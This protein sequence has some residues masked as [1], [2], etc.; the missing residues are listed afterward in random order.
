MADKEIIRP[1][2]QIDFLPEVRQAG[3]RFLQ[4]IAQ[5]VNA[6]VARLVVLEAVAVT[7]GNSHDHS[8]GD[9]AQIAYSGLSG[10]PTYVNYVDRGDPSAVDFATAAFTCDNTWRDLD[11]SSVVP[12]GAKAVLLRVAV[13]DATVTTYFRVRKNGNTNALANPTI[14]VQVADVTIE[15]EFLV[16]CD[17]NRVIEYLGS[18][19]FD[20][21]AIVI[22]GW[23]I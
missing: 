8:G 23:L 13:T 2:Q 10:L 18:A 6:A 17:T 20:D 19:A 1:P 15:G 5:W 7:N 14:R 12:A 4:Q 11:L 21:I 16:A 3:F 22:L 9:G